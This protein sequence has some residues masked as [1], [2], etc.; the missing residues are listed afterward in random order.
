MQSIYGGLLYD[1]KHAIYE[2]NLTEDKSTMKDVTPVTPVTPA[3]FMESYLENMKDYLPI[4]II[5]GFLL[6]ITIWFWKKPMRTFV[7]FASATLLSLGLS[8][9]LGRG[10][11]IE[12]NVLLIAGT[13]L[14]FGLIFDQEEG[15]KKILKILIIIFL[16]NGG[17][18][19]FPV[20]FLLIYGGR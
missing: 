7:I 11:D 14:V 19:V 20:L 4:I 12:N 5:Q 16:V 1:D 18:F 6:F 17:I 13:Q 8:L 10:Y 2:A 3:T 9:A 15:L